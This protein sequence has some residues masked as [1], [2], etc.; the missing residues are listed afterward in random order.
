MSSHSHRKSLQTPRSNRLV[1]SSLG[2]SDP[3]VGRVLVVRG[4][5]WGDDAPKV[6]GLELVGLGESGNGGLQEVSLGSS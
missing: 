1:R 4:L 3:E 5:P 6:G 2:R